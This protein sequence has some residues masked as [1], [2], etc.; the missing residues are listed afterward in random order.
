MGTVTEIHDYLRILFARLGK[1]YCPKCD[2]PIGTQTADE[3]VEKILHQ[4]EGSKVLVMAPVERADGEE[5]EHLWEE[6]RSTGFNR[7]RI[8]GATTSL[9]SPPTLSHRRK[10][11][12]EVVIDRAIVKRSTRSRLA[13]SIESA[14]D[15]GKG[16]VL[17]AHADDAKDEAKWHVDRYSQ[18]RPARPAAGLRGAVAPPFLVQQ[19]ARLVP[20]VRGPGRPAGGQ[21][22]ALVP[23]GRLSLDE[24]AIA[25]WPKFADDP[26]FASAIRAMTEALGISTTR[27]ST[28]LMAG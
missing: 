21:P 28:S 4:P 1:P 3:I 8:D 15:L 16:V 13:D 7:V 10:H 17:I 11:K 24:G 23:N 20:V 9:D 5:Y 22:A 2:T 12:I 14:L 18:H 25:A 19:P 26:M 27:R 6:L